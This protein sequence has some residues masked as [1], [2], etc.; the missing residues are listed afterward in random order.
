LPKIKG[1]IEV[2]ISALEKVIIS[3]WLLKPMPTIVEKYSTE[4]N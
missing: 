2:F 4:E 1:S 3:I